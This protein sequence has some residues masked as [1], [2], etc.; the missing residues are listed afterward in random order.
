M[1]HIQVDYKDG[2]VRVACGFGVPATHVNTGWKDGEVEVSRNPLKT[3]C[4][5][6]HKA[7][8]FSRTPQG[9]LGTVGAAVLKGVR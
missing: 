8:N 2:Q 6:C 9:Q 5:E 1:V 3:D 4:G 7:F